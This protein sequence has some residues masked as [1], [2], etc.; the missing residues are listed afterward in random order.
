MT[1]SAASPASRPE[2][3]APVP[4]GPRARELRVTAAWAAAV[5][6]GAILPFLALLASGHTFAFRDSVHLF[7]PLR[8]AVVAALREGRLPLWNPHEAL[9]MPL[10][11]QPQHGVLHPI[12]ILGAL[13]VPDAGMDVFIVIH[14]AIAALGTFVLTRQLGA[15][16][17]AASLAALAFALSGYVLG[18]SS[19]IPYL[20]AAAA[21]PWAI[22][23]LRAAGRGGAVAVAVAALAVGVLLLAGDPQWALVAVALGGA[24]ALEAGGRRGV[25]RAVLAGA[26]GAALAGIQLAPTWAFLQETSRSAEGLLAS[27]R[28]QWALAPWR[29]LELV[30]PGFFAGRPGVGT[31]EVFMKLGHPGS[32]YAPFLPS[33]HLGVAVVVFAFIGSASSRVA[34]LLAASALVLLWVALG[35]HLGADQLLRWIPV[36]G[37]FRYSEKLVG[38]FTLCVAVLAGLGADRLTRVVPRVG[39][40]IAVV[41]AALAALALVALVVGGEGA[42]RP[43]FEDAAAVGWERVLVGLAHLVLGVGLLGGVLLAARRPA[44]QPL[45]PGIAAAIVLVASWAAAPFALH[46]GRPGVLEPE[47]LRDVRVAG[48]VTRI[49][50]P[51]RTGLLPVGLTGLDPLDRS[52]FV[53]SR[54]GVAPYAASSGVDHLACY[55]PLWPARFERVFFALYRD[56]GDWRWVAWR[57]FSVNRVVV[58]TSVTAK[59]REVAVTAIDGGRKIHV[60]P[61]AGFSVWEVPHRSFADFA[62]G[63]VPAS[64]E[65]EAYHRMADVISSGSGDVVVEVPRPL[66]VSS[67][68]V[69]SIER[70]GERLRVEAESE[71]DGVLVLNDAYW[72]GWIAT[73]DG[74]PASILRAD[75][76]VRAVPWPAGRH[77]L[78]MRY[79]PAEVRVG[80][81]LTGLGAIGILIAAAWPALRRRRDDAAPGH[82]EALEPPG[83]E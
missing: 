49:I 32:Y 11:A 65:A 36:W 27:E 39:V 54:M 60:D 10:F 6:A 42:V 52:V 78:E 58:E 22:A 66:A 68:R 33:V 51:T 75:V 1:G 8:P 59:T 37:S 45:V 57:R 43:L 80:A 15:S 69:L 19:N 34:R 20:A 13:L 73:I 3:S 48:G 14:G 21:A 72:P 31:A 7:A 56:Y 29:V 26:L 40:R 53:E 62:Q 46:A 9:G 63:I 16:R 82:Q 30:M 23:A 55:S 77:V 17:A 74:A 5:V 79:A 76:L 71:S 2:P 50:T 81:L 18:M 25:A 70:S 61:V 12:S 67:G 47:P 83:T 24:L 41:C 35:V 4:R 64:S 28:G 38:P 44:Q